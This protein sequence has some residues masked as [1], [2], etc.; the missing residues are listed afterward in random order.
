MQCPIFAIRKWCKF[1]HLLAHINYMGYN[2]QLHHHR[3]NRSTTNH[4][5]TRSMEKY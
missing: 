2:N 5:S 1:A 3:P 4:G